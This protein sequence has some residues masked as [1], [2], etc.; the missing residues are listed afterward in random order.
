VRQIGVGKR[1]QKDGLHYPEGGETGD[2]VL[3]IHLSGS[4]PRAGRVPK[5]GIYK[6]P[7]MTVVVILGYQLGSERRSSVVVKKGQKGVQGLKG[8]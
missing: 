5:F 3:D 6:A 1:A 8:G 2:P 4:L 7:K